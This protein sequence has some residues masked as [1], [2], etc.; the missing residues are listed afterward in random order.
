MEPFTS[1]LTADGHAYSVHQTERY[2]RY[3]QVVALHKQ[4]M[5]IKEIASRLGM[6]QRTVQSWLAHDSYPETRYQRETQTFWQRAIGLDMIQ[7]GRYLWQITNIPLLDKVDTV[8]K[9]SLLSDQLFKLNSRS[10]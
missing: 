6:G 3:Q 1:L 9:C 10:I 7:S 5:K 2:E 8:N 4:G